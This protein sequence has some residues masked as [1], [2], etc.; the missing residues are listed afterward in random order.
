[1]ARFKRVLI[2]DGYTDEPAGFGVPPYLDVYPRYIAG[3]IWSVDK[4]VSI[5]Y[6]TVDQ[7]RRNIHNFLKQANTYDLLVVIAGAIVPGKYL[8]GEPITLQELQTWFRLIDRPFKVL[9]GA[10]ARWG[11]GNIGGTVA[12]LPRT[13][14]ENFDVIVAGEPEAYIY[15]LFRFGEEKAHPWSIIDDENLAPL[16]EFSRLGARI[17]TQHPN[18]GYNLIAEIET[19]RGCPRWIS[20]GC[21]FC[22][23]KLY[24][25]PRQRKVEDVVKEVEALYKA[26]VRHFRIGRQADIMTYGSNELAEKEWP[27]PNPEAIR[28][29]FYGIR[30]VAPGLQTLHIDNVNPGTIVRYEEESIEI[31]K[32]I[33]QYH[34]PG[35]VAA[36]G[37]ETADPRVVKANNLKTYPEESL[38]A[39]E[40]INKYGNRPGYNG[41]PELLPGI[42]F[43]LG[44]IGETKETYRLNEEFL[45]RIYEK[46]LNVRRINVRKV[47]ILPNTVLAKYGTKIIEKHL[48]SAKRF[49]RQALNYSRLFLERLVPRGTI[50]RYLYVEKYDPQL[51]VTFAR[52]AGSYPLV[53]EIP[54]KIEVKAVIDVYI[55]AH[56]SRS[57]RGLPIPLNPNNTP[58]SILTRI[59]GPEVARKI[60]SQRPFKSD[61]ELRKIIGTTGHKGLLSIK[62]H[63]CVFS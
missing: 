43:V 35:D 45:R 58:L 9:A 41:L 8:G 56:S 61:I 40:I 27:R 44:L 5:R 59:V 54:C 17:V 20:G 55:Y 31:L 7:A 14:K 47:L 28:R 21:S 42:N 39:I 37:I 22:A 30:V 18:Y 62:G 4:T 2:L 10:A 15:E 52:Q 57:V 13:V 16:A 24:G 33:I 25:R 60:I 51:K 26:G 1:M 38:R 46:G 36:L 53:V 34:T 50:L 32:I 3:A 23:T 19:Y 29:L 63:T 12:A 49:E 6:M 11:I 48:K